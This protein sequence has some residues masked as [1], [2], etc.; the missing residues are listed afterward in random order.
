VHVAIEPAPGSLGAVFQEASAP[1]PG[2]ALGREG[3]AFEVGETFVSSGATMPARAPAS[4][5]MFADRHPL[6]PLDMA[7]IVEPAYSMACPT[8]RRRRSSR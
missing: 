5:D 8:H 7:R 6:G 2:V 1:G 4:I 3:P